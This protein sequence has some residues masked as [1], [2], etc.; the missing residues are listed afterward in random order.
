MIEELEMIRLRL[1]EVATQKGFNM[2]TLSRASDVP[3]N[4]VRRA[5]K[6]DRYEIKLHTLEKLAET[7]GVSVLDLLEDVPDNGGV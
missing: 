5:W 6:N 4:T 2:A 1:R 3:I 7:L